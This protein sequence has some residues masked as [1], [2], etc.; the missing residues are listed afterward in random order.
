TPLTEGEV[1]VVDGRVTEVDGATVLTPREVND[2]YDQIEQVAVEVDG[3]SAIRAMGVNQ[4]YE[5]TTVLRYDE[6]SD[7][8]TDART[9]EVY[10]VGK[11]GDSEFFVDADGNRAFSQSWL[12]S[13]GLSNYERLFTNA[14]IGGQFLTSDRKST[15]L[16]SSHVSIS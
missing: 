10:T 3:D 1:T 14:S 4:A 11:V 7:S 6:D 5:G 2:A 13:I 8:I 9:G 16:N 12:Q 15:R